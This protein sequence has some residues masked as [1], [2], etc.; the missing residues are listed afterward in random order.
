VS[1][2]LLALTGLLLLA[3]CVSAPPGSRAGW[4]VSLI[5]IQLGGTAT[6]VDTINNLQGTNIV[7]RHSL[8]I[9]ANVAA[10]TTITPSVTP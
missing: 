2:T 7:Q 1:K 6:T 10:P 9:D 5:Q 4:S 8:P 3:G